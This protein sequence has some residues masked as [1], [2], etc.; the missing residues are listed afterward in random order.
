MQRTVSL[1][2]LLCTLPLCACSAKPETAILTQY[3]TK[4]LL[5]IPASLLQEEQLPP[6]L[7]EG[8]D[9]GALEEAYI[10]A[11]VSLR[12]SNNRV[13]ELKALLQQAQRALDD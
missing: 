10:M 9:I 11:V 7:V 13:K 6:E 3:K 4:Q 2:L 1:L 5:H 8:D 12:K